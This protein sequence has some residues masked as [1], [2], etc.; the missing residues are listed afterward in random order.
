M[1]YASVSTHGLIPRRNSVVVL[2]SSPAAAFVPNGI[3]LLLV[4]GGHDYE[5]CKEDL[6]LYAPKVVPGVVIALDD[7]WYESVR[8]AG[9]EFPWQER[10]FV[11]ETAL[12]KIEIYLLA[13]P[14][15]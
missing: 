1:Y 7:V 10:G 6:C 15:P 12:E 14:N 9:D 11:L 3:G 5:V 2:R 13:N 4:D 8:R